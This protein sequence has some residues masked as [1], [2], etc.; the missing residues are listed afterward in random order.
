MG[1]LVVRV[2]YIYQ[3]KLREIVFPESGEEAI[4]KDVVVVDNDT[5]IYASSGQHAQ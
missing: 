2:W 1:Y 3:N 5:D 4:F